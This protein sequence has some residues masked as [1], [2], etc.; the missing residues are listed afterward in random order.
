[1][2]AFSTARLI[3]HGIVLGMLYGLATSALSADN[4]AQLPGEIQPA[5][6]PSETLFV[7]NIPKQSLA[8]AL[9]QFAGI[10]H[11]A[12]LFSSDMVRGRTSSALQG[13]FSS[14]IG[15]QQLLDATGLIVER[16]DVGMGETLLLKEIDKP[17]APNADID[18]LFK[19]ESYPGLIQAH[20]WQALCANAETTPGQYRLLLQFQVDSAGRLAD[21]RLLVSTGNVRRDAAVLDTVRQ[22]QV[23]PPPA[24]LVRQSLTMSLLPNRPGTELRCDQGAS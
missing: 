20:L 14:D 4:N 3:C 8:V 22:V 16:H 23:E 18:V 7:F 11:L 5:F 1:M 21:A 19:Q 24:V 10:T 13:R 17:A 9:E 6:I 2:P 12:I 15:L